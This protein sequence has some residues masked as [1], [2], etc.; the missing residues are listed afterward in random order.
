MKSG[1]TCR[2]FII[3]K[4]DEADEYKILCLT[5]LS[6]N[7]LSVKDHQSY[8]IVALSSVEIVNLHT[9]EKFGDSFS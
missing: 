7:A 9:W 2:G 6:W 3:C 4:C 8:H 1:I 5:I